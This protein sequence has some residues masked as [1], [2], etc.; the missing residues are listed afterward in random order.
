MRRR[1]DSGP[2]SNPRTGRPKTILLS[3]IFQNCTLAEHPNCVSSRTSGSRL[4]EGRAVAEPHDGFGILARRGGEDRVGAVRVLATNDP[5]GWGHGQFEPLT[6]QGDS[7]LWGDL[8]R[9][10]QAPDIRPPR[11]AGLGTQ[12][13]TLLLPG[14]GPGLVGRHAPLPVGFVDVVRMPE[15]RDQGIG[16][17]DRADALGGKAGGQPVLPEKV[18]GARPCPSPGRWA[19]TRGRCRSP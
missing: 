18:Q 4:L 17:G 8:D 7:P 2:R 3:W 15:W 6:A 5:G 13:G 1:P 16:L 19:R 9:V 12:G 10:S 11:A 14:A